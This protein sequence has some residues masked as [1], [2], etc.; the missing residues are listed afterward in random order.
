[1]S[2]LTSVILP[3][4]IGV[5]MLIYVGYCISNGGTHVRGKGWVTK[6]EAPKSYLA[7]QIIWALFGLSV[8]IGPFLGGFMR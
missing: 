8:I 1:M 5:A 3:V 4:V 2:D 7:N 6:E